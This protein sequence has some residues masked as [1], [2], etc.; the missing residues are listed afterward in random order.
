MRDMKYVM[1]REKG[2][3]LLIPDIGMAHSDVPGDWTSAGYVSFST[4]EKDDSGNTI[5]KPTCHGKSVS[6]GLTSHPDD[7]I[8]MEIGLKDRW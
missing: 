5:V 7:T 3:F 2:T 4:N 6:L 8:F 1:N